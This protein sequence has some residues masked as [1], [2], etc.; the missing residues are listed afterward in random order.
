MDTQL[1]QAEN[2]CYSDAKFSDGLTAL[3]LSSLGRAHC[4]AIGR[5]ANSSVV[6]HN[7]HSPS[8]LAPFAVMVTPI[9]YVNPRCTFERVVTPF[10]SILGVLQGRHAFFTTAIESPR[11]L[12]CTVKTEP[13]VAASAV[14]AHCAPRGS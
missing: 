1:P 7:T 6:A 11:H 5:P 9:A 13:H 12:I 4:T 8:H 14:Y 3:G 10:E 2:H